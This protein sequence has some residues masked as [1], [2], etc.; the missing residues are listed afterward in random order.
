MV[1]LL[2]S[3]QARHT[4]GEKKQTQQTKFRERPHM[5]TTGACE[6]D[7]LELLA[8]QA[9]RLDLLARARGGALHPT[10][11]RVAPHHRSQTLRRVTRKA[12]QHLSALKHLLPAAL[13]VRV[14]SEP[15]NPPMIAGITDRGQ[16][17]RLVEHFDALSDRAY[18]LD[19]L[20]VDRRGNR[21]RERTTRAL[22][23]HQAPFGRAGIAFRGRVLRAFIEDDRVARRSAGATRSCRDMATGEGVTV[24][25][26]K[27]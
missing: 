14:A 15:F 22:R 25:W 21:D 23:A 20:R 8:G 3:P 2:I 17:I 19:Q 13:T 10:Q 12:K 24:T 18:L 27:G 11:P 5:H 26:G 6:R 4:L 9:A 1:R 16:Q 7:A